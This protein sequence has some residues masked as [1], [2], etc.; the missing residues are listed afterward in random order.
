MQHLAEDILAQA[1]EAKDQIDKII[2]MADDTAEIDWNSDGFGRA[3][4]YEDSGEPL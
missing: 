2:I 3:D 1:L 4:E